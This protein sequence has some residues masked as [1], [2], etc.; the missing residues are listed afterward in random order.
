MQVL[1]AVYLSCVS[2]SSQSGPVWSSP[3]ISRAE[4]DG[5]VQVSCSRYGWRGGAVVRALDLRF[6]GRGFESASAPLRSGLRQ[7]TYTC[8]PLSP[9]SITWYRSKGGDTLGLGR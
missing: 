8:V 3:L 9:S 2:G 7:A 6:I 4:I 5:D 1:V